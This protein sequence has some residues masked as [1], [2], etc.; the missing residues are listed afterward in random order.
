[1]T[2]LDQ[3]DGCLRDPGRSGQVDLAEPSTLSKR[4]QQPAR[5]NV[6]HSGHDDVLG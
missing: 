4:S 2:T 5:S 1:M 6:V 3:G